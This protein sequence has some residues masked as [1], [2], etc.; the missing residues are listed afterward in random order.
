M[1]FIIIVINL[2][3]FSIGYFL[4]NLITANNIIKDKPTCITFHISAG[5]NPK[6]P[7]KNPLNPSVKV[8]KPENKSN[9]L[10]V[11]SATTPISF[12]ISVRMVSNNLPIPSIIAPIPVPPPLLLLAPLINVF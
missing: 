9:M 10:V 7:D 12:P 3:K 2:V 8:V 4:K 11:K 1:K 6:A 5:I